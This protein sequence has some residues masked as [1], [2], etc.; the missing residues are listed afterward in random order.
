MGHG[1]EAGTVRTRR[2]LRGHHAD[3]GR[4]VRVRVELR[5]RV[6]VEVRVR[7]RVEVRVR[8]RVGVRLG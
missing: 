7:V 1:L 8:I 3:D 6:R 5:V 2:E 4:L